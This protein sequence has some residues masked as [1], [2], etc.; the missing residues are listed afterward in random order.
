MS[1]GNGIWRRRLWVWLPA[2]VFFVLNLALFSTYRLVVAGRLQAARQQLASKEKTLGQLRHQSE[3]LNRRVVA[4]RSTAERMHELYQDRFSTQSRR[5]TAVTA[6]I[7]DLARRAGLAPSAMSY[8][9]EEIED[10]GLVK[11]SFTFSVQGTY[12]Q[13]RQ[14]INLLELTPS[15]VT[16]EQVSLNGEEGARLG[17][18]LNLSTLFAEDGTP[19]PTLEQAPAR[20]PAPEQ[21]RN[22][23]STPAEG[24]RGGAS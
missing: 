7:R 18:R 12:Q 24:A 10:Y 9:S 1:L 14:F 17:I 19:A 6:E 11:R 13:L 23:A 5:F 2:L 15:F 3:A 21:A 20:A 22:P 4:A 16:L 8:P